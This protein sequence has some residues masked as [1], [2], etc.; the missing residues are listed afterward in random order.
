MNAHKEKALKALKTCRGQLDGIVGMIESGRYCIDIS[1][2][3]MAA[4]AM[5]KR[6]NK[7]ILSQH[8]NGCVKE[9]LQNRT[10]AEEKLDEIAAVMDKLLS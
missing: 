7:L 10:K 6:A 9:A 2:Q 4:Q 5:L 3:I 8:V 1:D